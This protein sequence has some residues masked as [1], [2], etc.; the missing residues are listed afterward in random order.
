MHG[1]PKTI[2]TDRD[3]RFLGHFWRNLWKKIGTKLQFSSSY[4]PQIDGKT[5]IVNWSLGNLLQS[6]VREKP[7]QWDLVLPQVEFSYNSSVNRSIG[8]SP[9]QA[10]YGRNPMGLLDLVQLALGDRI[11]DDGEPFR[12][13]IQQLHQ[14]VRQKMRVSNE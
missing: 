6:I 1:V 9:F 4:H 10:V 3:T 12:E 2:T 11:N 5:E 14:Q 13:H 8:K 7:K